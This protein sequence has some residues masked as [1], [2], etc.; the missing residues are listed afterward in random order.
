MRSKS[1]ALKELQRR[2]IKVAPQFLDGVHKV[3]DDFILHPS[4]M[5]ALIAT[6]RFGK[7]YSCGLYLYKTAYENPGTSCVYIALT[8]ESAKKIMF[9]DILK[10]LNRKYK[11]G[12]KFNETSLTVTLPN[13][14]IIYLMGVDAS[15][16]E[17]DKLLGQKY[18]LAVIDECASFNIDLHSLVYGTLKPAMADLEGTIAMVGTPG[19]LTKSLFYD[20]T[21]GVEPG[22]HVVKADTKDNPYMAAKWAEEIAELTT[23]QPYIVETPMFKQMYL[24]QWVIDEDALVYKFNGDRNVYENLP[25]RANGDWQYL[26]GVDLGYEDASAFVVVAYHEH[27]KVLYILDTYSASRMDIT[28]VADKIRGLKTKYGIY[29][30]VIDGA[31]KQAV[32]EIQK[33]HQIPLITADKTGKSDFIEIMNSELILGRIKAHTHG[34]KKL[35]EE[36]Q[37]LVWK[38]QKANKPIKREENPACANHLADACLYAWRYCYQ[39]FSERPKKQ[40]TYGSKEWADEQVDSMEEAAL[41]YFTKISE[42]NDPF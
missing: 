6:R 26:L 22:W 17:K 18:K 7:S 4:R 15:E 14:S 32:E 9:K 20:I 5:K 27:D 19:N 41:E 24:G 35:I 39:Y 30:V 36:W 28:D 10:P 23:N 31:N 21:T 3:Q 13:G 11:L 33:R 29:K 2:Q 1:L 25:L 16:D 38:E 12:G 8:R 42:E 40:H 37:G 34:A